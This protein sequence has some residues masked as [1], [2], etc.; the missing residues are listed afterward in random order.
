LNPQA[1]RSA[2]RAV[3]WLLVVAVAVVPVV[4]SVLFYR[5]TTQPRDANIGGSMLVGLSICLSLTLA[6][7]VHRALLGNQGRWGRRPPPP[8]SG[9][10]PT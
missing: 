1:T 2:R 7:L 5:A 10:P 6:Y 4:P 8:T 3:G 9:D